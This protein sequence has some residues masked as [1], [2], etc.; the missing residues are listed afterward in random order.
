MKL[1]LVAGNRGGVEGECGVEGGGKCGGEG[2]DGQGRQR[3][4]AHSAELC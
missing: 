2:R 3:Q 1:V 4:R